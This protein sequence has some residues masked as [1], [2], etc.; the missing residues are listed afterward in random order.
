M[1]AGKKFREAI[2][3]NSPLIIPGVINAYAAIL[4]K[5]SNHKAIYLSGGGVAAASYG[6]PDMT[7]CSMCGKARATSLRIRAFSGCGSGEM[8]KISSF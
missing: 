6:I 2:Q 3:E 8:I 4:A 7:I 5:K 1:S